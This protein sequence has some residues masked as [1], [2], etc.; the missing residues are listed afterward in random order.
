[1][2]SINSSNQTI[3][4]KPSEK[5]MEIESTKD[6]Y[7]DTSERRDTNGYDDGYDVIIMDYMMPNLTGPEALKPSR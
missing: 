2:T 6:D 1:M 5:T 4:E 7:K 3:Q